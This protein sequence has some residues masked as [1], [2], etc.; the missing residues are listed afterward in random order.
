MAR[1]EAVGRIVAVVNVVVVVV[2][3]HKRNLARHEF[4]EAAE[5][6]AEVVVVARPASSVPGEAGAEAKKSVERSPVYVHHRRA[7]VAEAK[8]PG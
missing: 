8:T 3:E 7:E 6:V 2:D 5:P 4:G 1:A